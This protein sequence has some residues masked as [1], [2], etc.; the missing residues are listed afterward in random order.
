MIF[1]LEPWPRLR[2]NEEAVETDL[3]SFEA[4]STDF[5]TFCRIA[6]AFAPL[7]SD[8]PENSP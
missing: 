3:P 1:M 7:L 2:L 4:S 5:A 8:R 6:A